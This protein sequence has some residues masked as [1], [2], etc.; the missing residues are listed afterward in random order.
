MTCK[1]SVNVW[2]V[3]PRKTVL[4]IHRSELK[5]VGRNAYI[6]CFLASDVRHDTNHVQTA[7]T[8]SRAMFKMGGGNDEGRCH[9]ARWIN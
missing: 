1:E 9:T 7:I 4:V 5:I 3:L 2:F 6:S 8:R